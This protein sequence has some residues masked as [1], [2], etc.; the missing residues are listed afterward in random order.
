MLGGDPAG[1]GRMKVPQGPSN[2]LGKKMREGTDHEACMG[3]PLP[4]ATVAATGHRHEV[5]NKFRVPSRRYS[6]G[7]RA[8]A[9]C[10][11]QPTR[12]CR[13]DHARTPGTRAELTRLRGGSQAAGVSITP[14][15]AQDSTSDL[16]RAGIA[17]GQTLLPAPC[18]AAHR[19]SACWKHPAPD[20][21]PQATGWCGKCTE[22]RWLERTPGDERASSHAKRRAVMRASPHIPP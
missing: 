2:R 11:C 19:R 9:G 13:R 17:P 8:G 22:L 16:R 15:K 12:S 21:E 3:R 4:R 14:E 7:R 18:P 6:V 20:H 5:R 10:G 1:L